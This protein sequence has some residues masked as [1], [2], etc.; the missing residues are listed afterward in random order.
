M[1]VPQFNLKSLLLALTVGAFVCLVAGMAVRGQPWAWAVT[2]GLLILFI[3]ALA[4]AFWFG[5][6]W[7]FARLRASKQIPPSP[8]ARQLATATGGQ[9][10]TAV[11]AA[12][13]GQSSTGNSSSRE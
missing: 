6:V 2:I 9:G 13:T 3:A 5:V 7:L 4:L 12:P 10:R 11:P 1:V 8:R